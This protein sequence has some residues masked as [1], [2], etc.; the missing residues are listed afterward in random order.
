MK[1]LTIWQPWAALIMAGAKRYEFRGWPAPHWLIGQRFV[2]HAGQKV[3][4]RQEIGS[5][6]DWL[7][8]GG[9]PDEGIDAEKALPILRVFHADP[10]ALPRAA[11][12]GTVRLAEPA[13]RKPGWENW[14]FPLEDPHPFDPVV[15]WR[16]A[17]GFWDWWA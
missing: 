13:V 3:E 10:S 15:P 2:V 17:Q 6:I 7:A 1:A 12:L 4:D 14:G 8:A 9:E 16:G 5:I 11:G